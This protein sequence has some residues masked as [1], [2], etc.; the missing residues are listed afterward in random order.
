MCLQSAARMRLGAVCLHLQNVACLRLRRLQSAACMRLGAVCLH[1]QSTPC[2]CLLRL[3]PRPRSAARLRPRSAMRARLGAALLLTVMIGT[4]GACRVGD[5]RQRFTEFSLGTVITITFYTGSRSANEAHA[6][7]LF[8]YTHDIE[9]R[10]STSERDYSDTELLRVNNNAGV[11]AVSISEDTLALLERGIELSELSAGDFTIAV[12]PL[13][14]LWD[15][16]ELEATEQL[17]AAESI[18]EALSVIDYRD[19]VINAD[20]MSVYLPQEGM[21]VDVGGVAKGWV[22]DY[23]RRYL[24]EHGVESALVDIGGN[25]VTVG[26]RADGEEWKIGI[27]DPRAPQGAI[28]G[29]LS[30][31]GSASVVTSGNYERY[32]EIDGVRYHHIIDPTTGFPVVNDLSSVTIITE[33]STYADALSTAAYVKGAEEG[34][35]FV[36]ALSGVE[37]IFITADGSI[38]LTDGVRDSFAPTN[39]G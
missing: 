13:S 22:G 12:W 36:A 15:F 27:Q 28:A 11:R 3:R 17:P 29:V 16:E 38:I 7:H 19:I 5:N 2:L 35:N 32:A 39:S 1:L 37:A 6:A 34:Y 31:A 10:M 20:N 24:E 14:R 21:G 23:Y 18:A 4:T 30:L 9:M 33:E 26:D 8:A 25:I